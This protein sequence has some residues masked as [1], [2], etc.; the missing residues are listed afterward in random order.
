[1]LAAH[2][3]NKLD[4]TVQD[5]SNEA[6]INTQIY[7]IVRSLFIGE[8]C[9]ELRE[10][11]ESVNIGKASDKKWDGVLFNNIK[12]AVEE[13]NKEDGIFLTYKGEELAEK[14]Y[15]FVIK[16]LEQEKFKATERA[17]KLCENIINF[18]ARLNKLRLQE[19]EYETELKRL[20]YD[21]TLTPSF[22]IG[23]NLIKIYKALGDLYIDIGRVSSKAEDYTDAAIFY[24][25]VLSMVER[26]EQEDTT[27]QELDNYKVRSFKQLEVIWRELSELVCISGNKES[28]IQ[29]GLVRQE[30]KDN[31]AFLKKL[32]KK[33]E[34]KVKEI[35]EVS[36]KKEETESAYESEE[37][38][39]NET[40]G[41]FEHIAEQVKG[42]IARIFKECE[43]VIGGSPCKYSVIGL[44]SLAL[45]QFT[46][47]SDLEFAILTDNKDYKINSNPKIQ[48]YFKNLSHLVHF[49]VICLGETIIPTS[50]YSINLESFVC[51][52]FNFDLGGKTPLGRIE[53]DKPYELIQTPEKMAEYLD[54]K[55]AHVD[56]NLPYILE[57]SCFIYGEQ[58]LFT[59][60]RKKVSKYLN[61]E[62]ENGVPNFK[63]RTL[64]RLKDGVEEHKINDLLNQKEIIKVKSDIDNYRPELI[65]STTEGKLFD[66]KQEIYRLPDR[67][68]YSLALFFGIEAKSAWDAVDKLYQKKI[69]GIAQENRSAQ[70]HLKY[71]TSFATIL[72][73]RAYLHYGQQK[74][75]IDI[76]SVD[77]KAGNPQIKGG[78]SLYDREL[79]EGGA[80]FK[81][82]YIAF[83]LHKKLDEFCSKENVLL[84]QNFLS[85]L[86]FFKK[87]NI[88]TGLIYKRLSKYEKAVTYFQEAVKETPNSLLAL[89]YLSHIL[90]INNDPQAFKYTSLAIAE[91]ENQKDNVSLIIS[92]N[93]MV[94][95]CLKGSNY[96]NAKRNIQKVLRFFEIYKVSGNMY[97]L[98]ENLINLFYTNYF[99]YAVLLREQGDYAAAKSCLDNIKLLSEVNLSNKFDNIYLNNEY[100]LMCKELG[101]Y[102]KAIKYYQNILHSL[103]AIYGEYSVSVATA[104]RNLAACYTDS[105]DYKNAKCNIDR[106]LE[107][108]VYFHDTTSLEVASCYK[109]LGIILSHYNEDKKAIEKYLKALEIYDKYLS[110]GHMYTDRV[111]V[112]NNLGSIYCKESY[113]E[114]DYKKA[115]SYFGKALKFHKRCHENYADLKYANILGNMA[116]CLGREGNSAS[117][118]VKKFTKALN[119]YDVYQVGGKVI[120]YQDK[121]N[122]VLSLSALYYKQQNYSESKIVLVKAI[123]SIEKDGFIQKSEHDS[124]LKDIIKKIHENMRIVE[125]KLS[126]YDIGLSERFSNIENK[127]IAA[128]SE[129]KLSLSC[130]DINLAIEILNLKQADLEE[131]CESHLSIMKT[132]LEFIDKRC[133]ITLDKKGIAILRKRVQQLSDQSLKLHTKVDPKL[134]YE[135]EDL[136]NK[137]TPQEDA[138]KQGGMLEHIKGKEKDDIVKPNKSP[139]ETRLERVRDRLLREIQTKRIEPDIKK[140]ELKVI[141][142]AE[143]IEECFIELGISKESFK[144]EEQ[145]KRGDSN[146]R[147][148]VY[149]NIKALEQIREQLRNKEIGK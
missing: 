117:E 19:Q 44:G 67:F 28:S 69:I 24:Q 96:G 121:Y 46:P 149:L 124:L 106:A 15:N 84:D 73:L 85:R 50:K 5:T 2:S 21:Y 105:K 146:Q 133:L 17:K 12:R 76:L 108:R 42:F 26:I 20:V 126:G 125:G 138:Y 65:E 129:F 90:E 8:Q 140:V 145:E 40:R 64:K 148:K 13:Y 35:D 104:L 144:V 77:Q 93:R 4:S 99:Q 45:N 34:Q 114:K 97:N 142:T 38:F 62:N 63:L 56:K 66:V 92:L 14:A 118:A 41:L 130:N 43:E 74:D 1:M 29:S 75:S 10:Y 98:P 139:K 103:K 95:L 57:A 87:D 136:L 89:G 54:E 51:R 109:V 107:I 141:G 82:Y 32:R 3:A 7:K 120:N 119:I 23:T 81:Y 131:Y 112:F 122:I 113:I 72:R 37:Y 94:L 22:E 31:R 60:Y 47:Y 135:A 30:S 16:R 111:E 127:I 110:N 102:E 58:S 101:E 115:I 48:N 79:E 137:I 147:S 71:A 100:A 33:A 86:N 68:I 39:T 143:E 9:R 80:L 27:N 123:S 88:N 91:S 134:V 59:N 11:L 70:H 18:N 49:K 116:M 132:D 55:Y 36:L 83:P 6:S 61:K 128:F 52:G 53:K 78:F 25:Y